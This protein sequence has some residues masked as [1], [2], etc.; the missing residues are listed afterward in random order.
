MV[1]TWVAVEARSLWAE[2]SW[3]PCG[4]VGRISLPTFRPLW[5]WLSRLWCRPFILRCGRL[6]FGRRR[7]SERFS[8]DRCFPADENRVAQSLAQCPRNSA[9][10]AGL[11][12]GSDLAADFFGLARR[13]P[14]TNGC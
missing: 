11:G 8:D 5:G 4:T 13:Q 12:F 1:C 6:A 14:R 2:S 3:V 9:D 10:G 7:R